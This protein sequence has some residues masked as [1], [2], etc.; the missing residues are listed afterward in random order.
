LGISYDIPSYI[1]GRGEKE[2]ILGKTELIQDPLSVQTLFIDMI[3]LAK[4]EVLLLLPTINAFLREQRLGIIQLLKQGATERDVHI[5]IL[6]P[7]DPLI[8]KS[9][10]DIAS[11][12]GKEGIGRKKDIEF[13]SPG[14]IAVSTVTIVVVDKEQSLVFEKKDDSKENFA[15]ALGLA[16]YS[17]SK[18]TVTAYFSIFESL[19]K[20]VLLYE[21]LKVH[22]KMQTEFI[23]IASHEM[24][25]PTQSILGY[26]ELLEDS[27]K[28][29]EE[30][31][32]IKR[33]A[34]RLQ[35]LAINLLD[36]S[37]IE[38]QTLN[39]RKEIVNINEKIL[40]VK[41]DIEN[42]SPYSR[43]VRILVIDPGENKPIYVQADKVRLYEVIANLLSNA[44]KFTQK[45]TIS[46]STE[47]ISNMSNNSGEVI[48]RISDT[49]VGI[50]PEIL[51]R[52]FT[53]FATRSDRGTGL[54]LFICKGI[55]EAHGGKI[56]AEN[57]SDG[58]GATFSFTLPF[59]K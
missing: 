57:N 59:G 40:N 9:L 25:T 7:T 26:A 19:W 34:E 28:K 18:P 56:W 24:K 33:N 37:R 44:L 53:K 47:I 39:L 5:K 42:Q 13:R 30:V 54:G 17:N 21:K 20:Q 22:D 35:K 12:E 3:K 23:N 32:A 2:V 16:T 6:V 41:K 36:V 38:S 8:E 11:P 49:G 45:G 58:N 27:C 31:D 51:S 52:L 10:G 55:V 15:E 1:K 43:A 29:S 46:I 48:I 14:E 50:H 4:H